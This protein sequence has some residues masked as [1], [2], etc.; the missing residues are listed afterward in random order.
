MKQR[1]LSII[2]A[3][4]VS[5][6]ANATVLFPFFGDI[7][8]DNKLITR[9]DDG[10]GNEQ[11]VYKGDSSWGGVKD[12]VNFLD[13]VVPDDVTKS[14]DGNMV[15]YTSPFRKEETDTIATDNKVSAIYIL[16]KGNCAIIY[17]TESDGMQ[18]KEW[19]A[20]IASGKM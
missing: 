4:L 11:V 18:Q 12:C 7:A 20:D 3:M 6:A 9:I 2:A 17:Y 1:G 15:V 13:D 5:A 10:D 8:A 16:D 19:Q 14:I